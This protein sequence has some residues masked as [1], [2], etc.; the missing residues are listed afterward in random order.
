MEVVFSMG[1]FVGSNYDYVSILNKKL[2]EE[3]EKYKVTKWERS[4]VR[5]TK[6]TNRTT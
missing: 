5:K 1:D 6:S 4:S 2:H 3:K